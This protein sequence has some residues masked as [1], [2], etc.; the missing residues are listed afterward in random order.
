MVIIN[1]H[2]SPAGT[3]L[4]GVTPMTAGVY[5]SV[6]DYEIPGGAGSGTHIINKLFI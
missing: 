2:P 3:G 5:N 4:I 1:S 6:I